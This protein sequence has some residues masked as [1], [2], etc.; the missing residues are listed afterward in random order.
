ME[1]SFR[2]SIAS[3]PWWVMLLSSVGAIT[4]SRFTFFFVKWVYI[5]FLRPPKN[6]LQYG[7]WGLITGCTDGIGKAIALEFSRRGFNLILIGR[8][9]EKLNQLVKEINSQF[10]LLELKTVVID[11]SG[12]LVAGIKELE[13]EIEGIDV[14]VLVNCA[15]ISYLH[16]LFLHEVEED[17]LMR[18]LRINLEALTEV[19]RV[20]LPV[21]LRKKKGA[22][23]NIGSGSTVAIPSHPLLAIYASTKA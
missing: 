23:L 15:G 22:I 3:H 17:T 4:A 21:M 11:L 18:M 7:K 12:D 6:L 20:V 16:T 9:L 10:P 13:L 8:N 2:G 14:G 1:L 19:T 5:F